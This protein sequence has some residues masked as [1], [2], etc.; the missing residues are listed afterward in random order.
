VP[1]SS[2]SSSPRSLFGLHD[3]EDQGSIVIW[4]VGFIYLPGGTEEIH[5]APEPRKLESLLRFEL[6][7][8]QI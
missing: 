1:S 8:S 5:G 6:N 4:N 3:S 7:A 2:G